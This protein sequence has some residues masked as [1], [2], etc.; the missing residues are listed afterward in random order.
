MATVLRLFLRSSFLICFSLLLRHI[1]NI[2]PYGHV[3]PKPLPPVLIPSLPP[4]FTQL[5]NEMRRVNR[6]EKGQGGVV[7]NGR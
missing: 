6:V 7:I 4:S 3:G 1:F 5:P 2:C